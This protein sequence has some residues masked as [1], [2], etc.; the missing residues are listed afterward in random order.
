MPGA[1]LLADLTD[2][3]TGT[4]KRSYRATATFEG[5]ATVVLDLPIAD[6]DGINARQKLC[7]ML[8][9]TARAA[10]DLLPVAVDWWVWDLPDPFS[11]D[12]NREYTVS[13]VFTNQG[14]TPLEEVHFTFWENNTSPGDVSPGLLGAGQSTP[15]AFPLIKQS[16]SW[17][18]PGVWVVRGPTTKTFLYHTDITA[19]DQNS[20]PYPLV[21]SATHIVTVNVSLAK[22]I[23][24]STAMAGAAYA[25][26][27]L[28]LAAAAAASVIGLFGPAETLL[29]ASGIAYAA[30][31][32]AG[33]VALDPPVPDPGF[34]QRVL[35]PDPI[36]PDPSFP[37]ELRPLVLLLQTI[38]QVFSIRLLMSTMEGRWLGALAANEVAWALVQAQDFVQAR[39]GL[40][41][42]AMTAPALYTSALP[43]LQPLVQQVMPTL[44]QTRQNLLVQGIPLA[45]IQGSTLT[46]DILGGLNLVVRSTELAYP[47]V[48]PF[49]SLADA[50]RL[51]TQFGQEV[52]Q[53]P[54]LGSAI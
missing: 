50:V 51:T 25:V 41:Q 1:T 40:T 4:P 30:A 10:A 29:A 27:L 37:Q 53:T 36:S 11:A 38:G 20:H 21:T 23:A 17:F 9:D 44:D 48:D 24:G 52:A 8:S 22:L 42:L 31:S 33:A 13:G 47:T 35:L 49:A 2:K 28:A 16:W 32:I 34:R 6:G 26:V 14:T 45:L 54:P 39:T 18:T 3:A 7:A 12:W 46:P 43:G 5:L 15:G 19:K